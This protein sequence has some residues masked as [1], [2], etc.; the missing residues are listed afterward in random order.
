MNSKKHTPHTPN[1]AHLIQYVRTPSHFLHDYGHEKQKN[2]HPIKPTTRKQQPRT[3][4]CKSK[5]YMETISTKQANK[6]KQKK[7]KHNG[8]IL[9]QT[10]KANHNV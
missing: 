4:E 5:E 6:T 3:E 9:Q 1:T 8:V 7:N 2:P 10:T